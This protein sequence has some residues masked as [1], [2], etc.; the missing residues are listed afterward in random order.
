[1]KLPIAAKVAFEVRRL[2]IKMQPKRAKKPTRSVTTRLS[3]AIL[4]TGQLKHALGSRRG[5]D[6][7]TARCRDQFDE[8]RGSLARGLGRHSVRLT[9]LGAPVTTTDRDDRK[10][11]ENDGASN[12]GCDFLCALDAETE[13]AVEVA[14][15]NEGFEASTLTGAGLL[16]CWCRNQ[17]W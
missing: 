10:L 1:M 12:S 4:N 8:D 16:L 11:G 9:E 17:H 6:T 15:G 7:G 13:M 14:N 2:P 5:D 3:V